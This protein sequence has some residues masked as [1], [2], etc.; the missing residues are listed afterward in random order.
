MIPSG[1]ELFV[2]KKE[3][4]LSTL[5]EHERVLYCKKKSYWKN[6]EAILAK[7]KEK[8]EAEK[9][10]KLASGITPGRRGRKRKYLTDDMILA[11]RIA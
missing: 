2:E 5:T 6:K 1:K 9:E 10:Q 4:D 3:I 8:Y 7:M 11:M